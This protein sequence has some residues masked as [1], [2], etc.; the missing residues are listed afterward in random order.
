MRFADGTQFAGYTIE[1]RLGRG[2]M[3][4]V[5]LAREA[6]LNRLVAL[7]VLPEQLADEADFAAR[8]AQEAQV[9][10]GL[11]HPNIIPLYRFGI[12]EDV[13]WMALRYVDGGDFADRLTKRPLASEEALKVFRGVAAALDYAHRK[14]IIHRDLKPQNILL[15]PDGAPYLADF[16][17]A[18]LLEGSGKL[19]TATGSIFGTPSYMAPEQA[20]GNPLGP[21]TDVYA[22]AVMC[23]Q[24][25]T[26]QLPFD[27]DTP[28][29]ILLKHVQEPLSQTAMGLMPVGVA[30][31]IDRGLAK[32]PRQRFQN[33]GAFI[34]ELERSLR[35]IATAPAAPVRQTRPHQAPSARVGTQRD[36][37]APAAPA[38]AAISATRWKAR[39][40]GWA[41]TIVVLG[42]GVVAFWPRIRA[43]IPNTAPAQQ[44]RADA[45]A[46]Q[47]A[48]QTLLSRLDTAQHDF[49]GS[50][51]AA[52]DVVDRLNSMLR[53]AHTRAE[54]DDLNANLADAK[55]AYDLA[56]QARD[57]AKRAVF[58][59][60]TLV[61]LKATRKR[62][63]DLLANGHIAQA[64]TALNKAKDG[65]QSLVNSL[66]AIETSLKFRN[67]ALAAVKKFTD[68]AQA[69]GDKIDQTLVAANSHMS[70]G[71]QAL[72]AGDFANAREDF[73][74]A[75]SAVHD[76]AVKYLDLLTE[77]YK[78]LCAA[79]LKVG[80]VTR[81]EEALNKAKQLAKIR[82]EWH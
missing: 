20:M 70:E 53:T 45:V 66:G 25:Q 43:L 65:L 77:K 30:A 5:Y 18:K 68:T 19:K 7:K 12:D 57:L 78:Q 41:L 71:T 14:G 26:G 58:E 67:E 36:P 74:Q 82:A 51:R 52:K 38:P 47:G 62:G 22:L 11:D 63:D 64:Q 29:A 32:D 75:K 31:V 59:S 8:F 73:A 10:A 69:Q 48:I 2:G 35:L 79:K 72:K 4:T 80:D 24:W 21:Y 56:T 1:S 50:A 33:A 3:A 49:D 60:N 15:T 61:D 27:A 44:S 6:G 54:S 76:A 13:P 55:M 34:E 39:A 28:H 81:A 23:F 40:A 9:I 37:V 16:G 46:A 42:G 17:V